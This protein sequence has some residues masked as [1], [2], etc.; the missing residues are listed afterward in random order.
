MP[1]ASPIGGLAVT[2]HDPSNAASAIFDNPPR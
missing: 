1:M 2:S